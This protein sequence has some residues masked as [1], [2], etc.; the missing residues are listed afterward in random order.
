MTK[1]HI[2]IYFANGDLQVT[3]FIITQLDDGRRFVI[4]TIVV[5][6]FLSFPSLSQFDQDFLHSLLPQLNLVDLDYTIAFMSADIRRMYGLKLADSVVAATAV[7]TNSV[8]LTRNVADF[9][10]MESLPLKK[11]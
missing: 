2:L 1:C 5:V 11:L 4:P 3:D 8:L 7:F 6:E 10:R 9:Q